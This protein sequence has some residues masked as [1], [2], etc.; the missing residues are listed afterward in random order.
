MKFLVLLDKNI[1]I[2]FI[3]DYQVEKGYNASKKRKIELKMR[4]EIYTSHL[5]FNA[6]IKL[7]HKSYFVV[8]Q[9]LK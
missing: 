5:P 8:R 2:L 3:E 6:Y 4:K 7:N 9:N 1:L